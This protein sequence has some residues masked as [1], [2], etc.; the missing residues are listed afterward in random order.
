MTGEKG[1]SLFALA[2]SSFVESLGTVK[3]YAPKHTT[4][5]LKIKK[6]FSHE[7]LIQ[8]R[9]T[10]FKIQLCESPNLNYNLE[11]VRYLN[12]TFHNV[13]KTVNLGCQ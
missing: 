13:T 5:N 12:N 10:L 6:N 8:P 9:L 2:N 3:N 11:I 1:K 4:F 7:I